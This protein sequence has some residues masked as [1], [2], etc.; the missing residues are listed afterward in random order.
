MADYNI[1]SGVAHENT[2]M[3]N[4][5]SKNMLGNRGGATGIIFNP[6]LKNV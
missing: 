4:T 2:T 6:P 5:F 1:N 3:Y